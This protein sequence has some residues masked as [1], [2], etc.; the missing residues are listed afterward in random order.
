MAYNK[1]KTDSSLGLEIHNH[2]VKQGVETPVE[3]MSLSRVEKI[4]SIESDFKNIMKTLGMD[5]KDDSLIDTPNRVAKMYVNEIF[6]GL[7]YKA[8]PKC[9]AVLNKMKYD[10]M[11]VERGISA[12]SNCEHHFVVIDGLATVGYIPNEKVLG[13]SKMNRIVEYFCKRPQIQERLTEQIWHTLSYILQTEDIAVLIDAQHFCVKSR[14]VEDIGS[15]TI[16]SKLGGAFKK[17]PITRNEF[18][19]L[20]RIE[21]K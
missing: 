5:L 15:S 4:N 3:E 16:T 19:A 7:D 17:D 18:M 8:F 6:W 13:L 14:G 1:I 21:C 12:Q 2:L 9:T 20:A 11:V 10:E